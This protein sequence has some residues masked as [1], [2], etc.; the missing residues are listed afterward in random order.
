MSMATLINPAIPPSPSHGLSIPRTAPTSK[1]FQVL[2]LRN[3]CVRKNCGTNGISSTPSPMDNGGRDD[4]ESSPEDL[5]DGEVEAMNSEI[6][7]LF[8]EA[9]NNIRFLDGQ[10]E[11]A[12][13][14]WYKTNEEK[15][16]LIQKIK[17]LEKKYTKKDNLPLCW[18]LILRID[19]MVLGGLVSTEE[20]SNLRRM[21]ID[22]KVSVADVFSGS[23]QQGDAEL[24]AELRHFSGG[25]K[26]KGFHIIHI[27]T[28]MEPLV[29]V[30]PL[31]SYIT[32]ISRALQKKGHLV[33]VI[34]P[35]YASLDLDEVQG[36]REVEVESYSY[37]YRRMH[38]NKIW[39]GFT[40]FS[41][42]SLD[43]IAKSGKQPDVLH[44]HNWQTAIVGPI[45]W[46]IFAKQCLD[47]AV[48][49]ALC[50][51]DPDRLNRP[52]RLQDTAKTHLVNILKGGIVYS[53]K[54]IVMSSIHS[55]GRVIHS[56]SHG[57]EPTLALHTGKLVVA[58]YGLDNS[59]WDPATDKSLPVPF[60]AEN[61][62]RKNA[63]RVIL[64]QQAGLETY[65]SSIVVGCIISEV[66]D[67]DLEKLQPAVK[68]ANR[69]GAQFVFLGNGAVPTINRALGYLQEALEDPKVKIFTSY[70]EALSRLVFA[71]SDIIC[72]SLQDHLLQVP[73]KALRYGAAPVL[74]ACGSGYNSFRYYADYDLKNSRFAKFMRSTFGIM[75]LS[76]ALDEINAMKL[77]SQHTPTLKVCESSNKGQ[78]YTSPTP[79]TKAEV[80]GFRIASSS[81]ATVSGKE[82][83]S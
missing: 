31:A 83:L 9:Q 63:C 4:E 27:C 29:S 45:F 30:G 55:K 78:K 19:S 54:V 42:A 50:G 67:F 16:L 39:T 79:W 77:T 70:D 35:K 33:E 69:R 71:G 1:F 81:S 32:G 72:H 28:E 3:R 20:A 75:S 68:N 47:E 66:S 2:S 73:L 21:V 22:S 57:L 56:M 59:T 43:Y 41:R 65:V 38:G 18:E 37:F 14:G 62:W 13:E 82:N 44:L 80:V 26:R 58:P 60:S 61:L 5:S 48:K 53:N 24:L 36:L 74:E 8:T 52:D 64:H 76:Q 7:T 15:Q 49:L 11:K 10:R 17:Q 23:L 25:S 46:D 51:L 6:W 40:Y 12:M 34:L